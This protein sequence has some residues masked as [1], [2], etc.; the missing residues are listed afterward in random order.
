[1]LAAV[2]AHQGIE[3]DLIPRIATVFCSGQA[4]MGGQCG[5]L[6]AGLMAL[7]MVEGRNGIS[8]PREALYQK[9]NL[10]VDGFRQEFEHTLCPDLIRIDLKSPDASEQYQAGGLKSQCEGYIRYVTTRTIQILGENQ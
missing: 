8:D 4:Q 9:A 5:A 7:S 2:A 6:T 1:M 10:L 3:S